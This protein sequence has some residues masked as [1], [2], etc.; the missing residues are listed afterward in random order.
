V[1]DPIRVTAEVLADHPLPDHGDASSKPERGRVLLLGGTA[2]TPGAVLLAGLGVLRAGAATVRIVTDDEVARHVA[3]ALPEALVAGLAADPGDQVAALAEDADC[4]V[5]GPGTDGPDQCAPLL[6]SVVDA[7]SA[8]GATVVVDAGALDAIDP[9]TIEPIASHTVLMPNP[10]EVCRLMDVDL[11]EVQRNGERVAVRAAERYGCTVALRDADTW[12]A[13]P[14]E[15][16]YL[17]TSGNAGLATSGSGDVLA[18]LLAGFAARGADP[19]TATLWAAHVHGMAGER[20]ADD[21]GE[22]GYLARE[23]LDRVPA[24]TA[25]LSRPAA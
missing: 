17:D 12:I 22:V 25:A 14:G 5:I 1:S 6:P 13:A 4:I 7:A 16:T 21:I 9:A 24:V 10:V 11:D 23:L 15:P 2:E 19:L 18:G 3:I 20:C 8:R